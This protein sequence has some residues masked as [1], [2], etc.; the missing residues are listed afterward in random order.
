MYLDSVGFSKYRNSTLA[1]SAEGG[2]KWFNVVRFGGGNSCKLFLYLAKAVN[3]PYFCVVFSG[4]TLSKDI[5]VQLLLSLY[6]YLLVPWE[7]VVF[8]NLDVSPIELKL[9][10][11]ASV[12][13]GF[14][15][16]EGPR[17][18]IF[19][20]FPARKMGREHG[21]GKTPKIPFL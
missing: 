7:T 20:V 17:N 10:C 1:A 12:S 15:C 3:G 9:A 19:G 18:G 4:R 8:E 11:V 14:G 6:T 2:L 16:A 5:H 13:V 21:A